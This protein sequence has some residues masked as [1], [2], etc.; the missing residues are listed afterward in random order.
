[1]GAVATEASTNAYKKVDELSGGQVSAAAQKASQVA[2]SS[3]SYMKGFGSSLISQ[4]KQVLVVP[5]EDYEPR[6]VDPDKIEIEV[7][8]EEKEEKPAPQK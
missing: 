7:V 3:F 8:E 4:V 5:P 2:W 6:G 1:M